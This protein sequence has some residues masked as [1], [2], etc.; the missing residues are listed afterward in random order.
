MN[1]YNKEFSAF[2]D[3]L[4]KRT[5]WLTCDFDCVWNDSHDDFKSV[6]PVKLNMISLN[7]PALGYN[8]S[9]S[10]EMGGV[11]IPQ[12]VPNAQMA[13]SFLATD[14]DKFEAIYR[15]QWAKEFLTLRIGFNQTSNLTVTVNTVFGSS[16]ETGEQH[17]LVYNFYKVAM[18]RP[19]PSPLDQSS[20]NLL[21]YRSNISFEDYEFNVIAK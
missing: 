11:I 9:N 1:L 21:V 12:V 10:E 6:N 20:V 7:I 2:I 16:A 8:F 18:S 5:P 19:S 14:I 17:K 13:F 4:G 15:R 3:S